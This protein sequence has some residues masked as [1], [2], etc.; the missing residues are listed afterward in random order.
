MYWAG[1][2][3]GPPAAGG[4][5]RAPLLQRPAQ[6]GTAAGAP[7]DAGVPRHRRGLAAQ[8]AAGAVPAGR[9]AA[10]A[11]EGLPPRRR[12]PVGAGA[13]LQHPAARRPGHPRLLLQQRDAPV[14]RRGGLRRQRSARR[15]GLR[16]ARL[17]GHRPR[18]APL[19]DHQPPAAA[20]QPAGGAGR[21]PRLRVLA[22]AARSATSTTPTRLTRTSPCSSWASA[23]SARSRCTRCSTCGWPADSARGA[24]RAW[25]SSS[26]TEIENFRQYEVSP[27]ISRF[28]GANTLTLDLN[29]VLLDFQQK[30]GR[31]RRRPAAPPGHPGGPAGIRAVRAGGVAVAGGRR[32]RLAAQPHPRLALL[33]RCRGRRRAL[34]PA[35]RGRA[36]AVRGHA[37]RRR[38]PIRPDPAGHV[39]PFE[40]REAEPEPG[41]TRA[42]LRAGPGLRQR[43]GQPDHPVADHRSGSHP[44]RARRRCWAS[45]STC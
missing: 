6:A 2:A 31:R 16:R 39:L 25:S 23:T 32:A 5:G 34:G 44:R 33:R 41:S 45:A 14:H 9:G 20:P 18:P 11:L 30:R 4:T 12:R 27:S 7:G 24:A 42:V 1:H 37:L 13:G 35:H 3:R 26:P 28:I 29:Y 10:V 36:G 8:A 38:R 22:R 21:H 15:P 43:P 40:H 17:L 19:R